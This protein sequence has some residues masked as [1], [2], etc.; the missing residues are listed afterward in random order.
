MSRALRNFLLLIST[1]SK[2]VSFNR[3][4]LTL[5]IARSSRSYVLKSSLGFDP[6]DKQLKVLCTTKTYEDYQTK[7]EHHVLTLGSG[8]RLKWRKVK[9]ALQRFDEIHRRDWICINGVLYYLIVVS[10]DEHYQEEFPDIVCFNV[11][12]EKFSYVKKDM[13]LATARGNLDSALANY[14]GKLAKLEADVCLDTGIIT[15]IK[16]WVLQDAEKHQWSG[17]LCLRLASSLE[18]NSWMP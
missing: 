9:C 5:P 18:D 17:Y 10:S 4:I 7:V 13:E 15:S 8:R 3:K 11:R 6:I 1:G 12:S 2:L 16:M 14:K